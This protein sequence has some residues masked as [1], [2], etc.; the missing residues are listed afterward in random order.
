MFC[1]SESRREGIRS[2]HFGQAHIA[3]LPVYL[4]F[5][6]LPQP[7]PWSSRLP[8]VSSSLMMSFDTNEDSVLLL[9]QFLPRIVNTSIVGHLKARCIPNCLFACLAV[10]RNDVSMVVNIEVDFRQGN[11]A[12]ETEGTVVVLH[13]RISCVGFLGP[14]NAHWL[15]HPPHQ[16]LNVFFASATWASSPQPSQTSSPTS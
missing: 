12:F 8:Q 15:L 6:L 2:P 10:S 14:Q 11:A 16:K 1:T 13:S 5:I 9:L 3:F 7:Y 4:F